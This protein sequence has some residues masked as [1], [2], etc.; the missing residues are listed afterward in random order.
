MSR[1][2]VGIVVIVLLVVVAGILIYAATKP[3]D[4][5]VQRSI[6][7][8]APPEKV[9]ALVADLHGWM[10]WSPYEKKDPAMQRTTHIFERGN[11][12]VL[13]KAVTPDVPRSLNP[14]P[15][16]APRNRLG[17]AQWI[18]DPGNP[19]TARVMVNR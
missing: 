13:G 4:F 8:K 3:N 2:V 12:L 6:A 5:R 16:K 14:F 19:L 11:W 9:M 7:I 1:K 15:A 10:V 17:L 18:T